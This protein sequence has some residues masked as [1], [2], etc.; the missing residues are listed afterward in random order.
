MIYEYHFSRI[1]RDPAICGGQ[2]TIRGSRVLVLDVLALIR[3]GESF[4]DIL[5][6]F[7][8]ISRQDIEEILL[9]AEALIAGENILYGPETGEVSA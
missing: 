7:P 5:D 8:T 4:D 6:D 3:S 9:Y 2:P 1:V